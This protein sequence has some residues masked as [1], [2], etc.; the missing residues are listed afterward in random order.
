MYDKGI[1][2]VGP[3]IKIDAAREFALFP[4]DVRAP[5][6]RG[7]LL[8]ATVEKPRAILL[9]DGVF[10]NEPAVLHKEVLYA[11]S[12]GVHVFG[13]ASMGALRAAEM[14]DFGMVGI[15]EI[16]ESYVSGR[17]QNDDAVAVLHAP[18]E[19]GWAPLTVALV[20][21]E[22]TLRSALGVGIIDQAA[23]ETFRKAAQGLFWQLRTYSALCDCVERRGFCASSSIDLRQWF[24]SNAVSQKARDAEDLIRHVSSL[25]HSLGTKF[26][27]Q[28]FF[29]S[30][31]EW[32]QLKSRVET[33]V[34]KDLRRDQQYIYSRSD[35]KVEKSLEFE[36]MVLVLT[37]QKVF[38]S[39]LC[40]DIHEL[41][42]AAIEFRREYG[43]LSSADVRTW[44]CSQDI[45]D[46]EYKEMV[47]NYLTFKRNHGQCAELLSDML[48][49]VTKWRRRLESTPLGRKQPS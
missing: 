12:E 13:A 41:N 23:F 14:S 43:L 9:V 4:L 17:R 48:A 21:I 38:A 47:E 49:R 25:W 15:G 26:A 8:R 40:Y 30:T 34:G 46:S 2:F 22:A 11:L 1:L 33:E 6:K 16:Y 19:L 45:T 7:D 35:A 24:E 10:E 37:N 3:T 18:S 29:E 20:D 44:M 32:E 28:F 42:E 5:A 39:D 27:A 31:A 36:S